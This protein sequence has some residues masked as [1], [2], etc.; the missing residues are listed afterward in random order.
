MD[1]FIQVLSMLKPAFEA[2]EVMEAMGDCFLDALEDFVQ[3][4]DNKIDDAT[5]LPAIKGLRVVAGIADNDKPKKPELEVI[6]NET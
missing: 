2:A 1:R 3:R 5:I 6:N 4:T